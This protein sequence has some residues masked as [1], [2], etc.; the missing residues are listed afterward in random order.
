MSNIENC[1]VINAGQLVK[2]TQ[3]TSKNYRGKTWFDLI[4]RPSDPHSYYP[5]LSD[6]ER[7]IDEYYAN[8]DYDYVSCRYF[9]TAVIYGLFK[10]SHKLIIDIDDNPQKDIERDLSFIPHNKISMRLK[11]FL[12]KIRIKKS[13]SSLLDN[14]FCSFYSSPI[15][16][17]SPKSVL[18]YNTT[19]SSERIPDISSST[20][21][22]ILIVS[23]LDYDPNKEGANH[24]VQY[25][26]PI[27]KAIDSSAEL[28]F[29]GKCSDHAMFERLNA[30][31]GVRALG[32]VADLEKEYSE[33]RVLAIPLYHGSGT[34]VK[35]VE[36]LMM[37]RP[38]VAT[39]YGSRGFDQICRDKEHFL[40][41][42]NDQEFAEGILSLLKSEEESRRLAN[43]AYVIGNEFF[44]QQGFMSI[45]KETVLGL[46]PK[47]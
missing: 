46:S 18:L 40:S 12:R 5:I 31:E 35:F 8:G 45:V 9:K 24:F 22:R 39:P 29:A 2:D 19:I 38:I 28:H 10:Y 33:A 16:A 20:P 4:F 15:E 42:N 21:H 25:V 30:V 6:R 36:G 3:G 44:S 17:P 47:D 32:Y 26:F 43:N 14:T 1:S 23:N 11:F 7:F 41:V 27:I 37:N 13:V 34:S